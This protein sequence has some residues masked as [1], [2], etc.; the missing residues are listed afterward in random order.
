MDA[1]EHVRRFIRGMT[2]CVEQ[3]PSEA[4]CVERAR[5]LMADLISRDDWLP[6]EFA[7]PH[8]QHYQQYLLYCDP[9]ERFSLVSFVWGPGQATPVHN[10]TVWGLIGML[11]GAELSQP[12][13]LTGEGRPMRPIRTAS[14]SASIFTARTSA[15]CG[16][17]CSTRKPAPSGA[18]SRATPVRAFPTSGSTPATDAGGAQKSDSTVALVNC[19]MRSRS[20]SMACPAPSTSARAMASAMA[21]CS[22]AVSGRSAA[23]L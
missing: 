10:H 6:D 22:R 19:S 5:A 2:Q 3:A 16:A 8:P 23:C 4:A 9:L 13:E 17:V 7:Q 12:Y 18:S 1:N 21:A 11:R 14:A 15:P 20:R